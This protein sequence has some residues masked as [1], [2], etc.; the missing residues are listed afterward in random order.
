MMDEEIINYCCKIRKY[1]NKIE[2]KI[3]GDKNE[4]RLHRD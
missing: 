3:R 4:R 2:E 1:A